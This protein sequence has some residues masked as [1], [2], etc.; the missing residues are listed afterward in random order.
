M[1]VGRHGGQF[2]ESVTKMVAESPLARS[3]PMLR[4]MEPDIMESTGCRGRKGG[5]VGEG[6]S[7]R[8]G[9]RVGEWVGEGGSEGG[10]VGEGGREREMEG[11][12]RRSS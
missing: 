7:E 3:H 12:N 8:E 1:F 4:A 6:G 9:G 10:W 2:T 5:W 11:E